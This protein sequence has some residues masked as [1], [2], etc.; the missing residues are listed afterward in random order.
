VYIYFTLED[1]Q[2]Y[3]NCQRD[4]GMK[5]LAELYTV[6][7]VGLIERVRRGLGKPAIIY[8]RKFDC[9]SDFQRS[10]KPTSGLRENRPP[11]VGN[12]DSNK[13]YLYG[14]ANKAIRGFIYTYCV[15]EYC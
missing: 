10:E 5:L 13:N 2:E 14:V 6:K 11:E 8:V 4:K 1:V 15:V 9:G 12:S 7:G 3:L